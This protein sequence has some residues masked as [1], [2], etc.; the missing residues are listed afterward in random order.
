MRCVTLDGRE[1]IKNKIRTNYTIKILD[2]NTIILCS[3]TTT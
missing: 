1:N 2:N 3:N